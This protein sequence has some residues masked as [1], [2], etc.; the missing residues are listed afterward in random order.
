MTLKFDG[1]RKEVEGA[2]GADHK[3]SEWNIVE[4]ELPQASI[5]YIVLRESYI[6]LIYVK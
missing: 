2:N 4:L 1:G 3:K 5:I 6:A